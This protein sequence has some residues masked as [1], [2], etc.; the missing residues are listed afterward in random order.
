MPHPTPAVPRTRID[1]QHV[2]ANRDAYADRPHLIQTA[3]W[4]CATA[5]GHPMRQSRIHRPRPKGT[6]RLTVID[7]GRA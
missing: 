4:V 7:G 1:A 6:P 5:N 2:L 3:L